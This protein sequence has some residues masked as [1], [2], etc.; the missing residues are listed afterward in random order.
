[1]TTE[2][3][4]VA[5]EFA[6]AR[7]QEQHAILRALF[8]RSIELKTGFKIGEFVGCT[9]GAKLGQIRDFMPNQQGGIDIVVELVRRG[10]GLEMSGKVVALKPMSDG[11]IFRVN[12]MK[13]FA[14]QNWPDVRFLN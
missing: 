12:D 4:S 2:Q 8:L 10:P 1:M 7:I 5:A 14:K 9:R 3:C 6:K 11:Q 13:Q